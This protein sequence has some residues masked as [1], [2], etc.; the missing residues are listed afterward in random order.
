MYKILGISMLS[1]LFVA[2][3]NAQEEE[4]TK[5][6]EV[7]ETVQNGTSQKTVVSLVAPAAFKELMKDESVQL[8]DVRTPEEYAKGK[9]GNA[10]NLNYFDQDFQSQ[11]STLDKTKPVLVYCASGRRSA[12]AVSLMKEMGFTEIHELKGGYN[13]WN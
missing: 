5:E 12:N 10:T 9:I 8:V 6:N 2:C 1:L 4:V 3:S 7:N 11:L 13:A